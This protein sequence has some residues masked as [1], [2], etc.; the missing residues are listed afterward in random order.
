MRSYL[1]KLSGR[2]TSIRFQSSK[3]KMIQMKCISTNTL[4]KA[5]SIHLLIA[6]NSKFLRGNTSCGV[7]ESVEMD[8]MQIF[9]TGLLLCHH[10][11]RRRWSR[12]SATGI[13]R[14]LIWYHRFNFFSKVHKTHRSKRSGS[15]MIQKIFQQ[16][17]A[18]LALDRDQQLAD[19]NYSYLDVLKCFKVR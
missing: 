19:K 1:G 9:H 14:R 15:P 8:Q 7:S 13:T 3:V 12:S 5:T 10:E 18:L 11:V 17:Q 16:T 4:Q 6:E 2:F